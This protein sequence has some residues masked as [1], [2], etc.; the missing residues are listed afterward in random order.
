MIPS[1][2]WLILAV[3]VTAFFF[4]LETRDVED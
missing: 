4:Y 1:Y 2:V 3:F